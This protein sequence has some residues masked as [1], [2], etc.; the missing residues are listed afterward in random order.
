MTQKLF[1]LATVRHKQEKLL[2]ADA[3]PM[4]RALWCICFL[5]IHHYLFLLHHSICNLWE[6]LLDY[7]LGCSGYNKKAKENDSA[8]I[9]MA[10]AKP[11]T[12]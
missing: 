11:C 8:G 1:N 3:L 7:A 5:L 2:Q 4:T 12:C 10:V 6:S 9:I